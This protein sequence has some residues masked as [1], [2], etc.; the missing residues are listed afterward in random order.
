MKEQEF[1]GTGRR[2]TAVSSIRLRPGTGKIEVNG[3]KFEEYFP[4]ALQRTTI[5]SPLSEVDNPENYDLI[6]RVKGGGIE[7][8]VI[9]S[10][11]GI[12]R[13]LVEQN[14]NNRPVLKGLGFLT[15]D[16]RKKERKKYGQ[17]GAR[18][19]FQFSKR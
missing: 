11:L 14:I 3:K 2:K 15:R 4:L 9:A 8:Q 12:S 10:R 19:R 1:I 6:I 18:K 7:G 17:P 13:A 5:L 16:S